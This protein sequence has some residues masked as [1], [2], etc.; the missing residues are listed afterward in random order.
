M[1]GIFHSLKIIRLFYSLLDVKQVGQDNLKRAVRVI[2][3]LTLIL[4]F[5]ST[6]VAAVKVSIVDPGEAVAQIVSAVWNML[7]NV[8]VTIEL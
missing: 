4:C 8:M 2:S 3:I 7:S 1:L 6:G 5:L